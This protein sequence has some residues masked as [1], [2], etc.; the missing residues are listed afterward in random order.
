MAHF[1]Q[2]EDGIVVRVLVVSNDDEHRGEDFL[3]EL[4]G[5]SDTWIQTSY[6]DNFRKQFAGPGYSYDSDADEFVQPQPY[7]SW[8]LNESNDWVAPVARPEDEDVFPDGP[9]WTAWDEEKQDWR[10]AISGDLYGDD[11]EEE[12]E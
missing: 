1:A 9:I 6:N 7:P 5:T 11:E 12:E 3:N 2:V 8:S 10:D 4:L